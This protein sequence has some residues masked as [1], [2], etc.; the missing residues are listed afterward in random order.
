MAT[1]IF[2]LALLIV[3]VIFLITTISI[4]VMMLAAL[5]ITEV[6]FL[7]VPK[8]VVDASLSLFKFSDARPI[9]YDLGSGDGRVVLAF[10][11]E[12]AS[13]VAIGYEIGPFPYLISKLK[14]WRLRTRNAHFLF[15]NFFN[16]DLSDATHIF[17]YLFP[18]TVEKL[19]EKFL[20]ELKPGTQVISCDFPFKTKEPILKHKLGNGLSKHTLYIYEF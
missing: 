13:A 2:F 9:F 5:F 10:A 4:A 8:A 1:T 3:S 16:D 20:K 11:E 19:H 7:P 18:N 6:P 17:I 12:H 15:R 14:R